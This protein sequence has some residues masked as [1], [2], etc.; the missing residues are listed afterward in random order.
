M[1]SPRYT[2]ESILERLEDEFSWFAR[3]NPRKLSIIMFSDGLLK[4]A[5]S[6][7][8]SKIDRATLQR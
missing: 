7:V 2:T 3:P 6:T 4:L 8:P 5:F 1:R